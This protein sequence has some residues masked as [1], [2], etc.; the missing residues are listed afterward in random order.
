MATA[1]IQNRFT[2]SHVQMCHPFILKIRSLLTILPTFILFH[3][4]SKLIS[5]Y[6]TVPHIETDKILPVWSTPY[7]VGIPNSRN[8]WKKKCILQS[9]VETLRESFISNFRG[10]VCNIDRTS[11]IFVH[12]SLMIYLLFPFWFF[13]LICIF[14]LSLSPSLLWSSGIPDKA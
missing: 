7:D 14:S 10:F 13:V 2:L 5:Y 11:Y 12:P 1:N 3:D 6:A 9:S 4:Y 8:M